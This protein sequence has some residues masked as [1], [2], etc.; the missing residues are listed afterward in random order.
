M[1]MHNSLSYRT[2]HAPIQMY[3]QPSHTQISPLTTNTTSSAEAKLQLRRRRAKS[4]LILAVVSFIAMI[5]LDGVIQLT[6]PARM[7]GAEH[8]RSVQK[9]GNSHGYAADG[10]PMGTQSGM[11]RN[12]VSASEGAPLEHNNMMGV[13]SQKMEVINS[14]NKN[15][16]FEPKFIHQIQNERRSLHRLPLLPKH[17]LQNRKRREL[18]HAQKPLPL[19]LREGQE[20]EMFHAQ[21]HKRR[22]MYP[23]RYTQDG[24]DM[25]VDGRTHRARQDK[26]RGR[27][28]QEEEASESTLYETGSLYQGYGT[29]YLDLWVGTPPQRQT[30]IVDTGSSVTAFPCT[31]CESCGTDPAT[32]V[33]YHLDPDYNKSASSTYREAQCSSGMQGVQNT[34][35]NI[36]T[37]SRVDQYDSSSPQYCKLAVA[38]AEGSTWTAA[39]GSDVVYPSGPHDAALTVEKLEENGIGA[40]MGDVTS[41]KSFEWPDFRLGFGCQTKVR[42][43]DGW[44]F[45]LL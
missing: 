13:Q 29:H 12:L 14:M 7:E 38:Y 24:I 32:G 44:E 8:S 26:R 22:R 23:M 30:V 39:E 3:E 41:G 27:R 36:G 9:M 6:F 19:H 31:G 10:E 16:N 1:P 15:Q 28:A 35:C 21:P 33:V 18:F 34:P 17:T 2:Q 11:V 45:K 37:C 42:A 20:D 40:G 5:F 25:I 4:F 43:V